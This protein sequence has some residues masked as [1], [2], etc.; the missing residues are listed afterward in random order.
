MDETHEFLSTDWIEAALALHDEY[1]ERLP[2]APAPVRMN[3]VITDIPHGDAVMVHVSIDTGT[4]GLVPQLGHLDDPELT[5]T[6]DYGTARALFLEQNPE[7]VGQAFFAG[8]IA[9]EG[10]LTRIFLLQSMEPSPE[11]EALAQEVNER[12]RSITSYS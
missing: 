9:V 7:A 1:H 6:L 10:D 11:D 5:V 3:L 8:R 4:H 2:E 12:L